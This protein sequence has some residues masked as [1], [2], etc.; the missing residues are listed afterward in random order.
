MSCDSGSC[1]LSC[2]MALSWAIPGVGGVTPLMPPTLVPGPWA[3][4]SDA[5]LNPAA[6]FPPYY[7]PPHDV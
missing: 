4:S 6:T 5:P 7:C 2:H 1:S 3:L